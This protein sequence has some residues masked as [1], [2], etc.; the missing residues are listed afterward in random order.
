MRNIWS[1]QRNEALGDLLGDVRIILK[2][3][4]EK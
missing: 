2:W 1:A 3:A 4:V